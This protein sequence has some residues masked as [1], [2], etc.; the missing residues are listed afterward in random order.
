MRKLD[1]K[2]EILASLFQGATFNQNGID[3][4]LDAYG[5]RIPLSEVETQLQNAGA[6]GDEYQWY[7]D[8]QYAEDDMELEEDDVDFTIKKHRGT[9]LH[10]IPSEQI[11]L[12]KDFHAKR[13][14]KPIFMR[15]ILLDRQ[16]QQPIFNSSQAF[17]KDTKPNVVERAVGKLG[18]RFNEP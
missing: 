17:V 18:V 15:Q 2:K 14:V 4:I 5:R 7:I 12:L 11:K 13:E 3:Y 9:V 10:F 8:N 1:R 6:I 16:P